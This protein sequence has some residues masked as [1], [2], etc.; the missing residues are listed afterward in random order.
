[1]S[2]RLALNIGASASIAAYMVH[3]VV[4][5]NLHIPA[6]VLL[7]AFV[8][9]IVAN[10]EIEQRETRVGER[11]SILGRFL[12]PVLGLTLAMQCYRLLPGEYFTERARSAQRDEQPEVAAAFALRGLTTEKWNP[13]LYR[14]LASAQFTLCDRISDPT[15]RTQCYEEPVTALEKARAVAPEDG[16][17]LVQL[18]SAY[19]AVGRY[20]EAEWVYYDARKWDPRSIYLDELYRFHL[21][22]WRTAPARLPMGQMD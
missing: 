1:L 18:A 8:F 13:N 22:Q 10:D 19:D 9:G 12:L 4:D 11:M 17:I 21:S 20:P 7:L 2:R 3:S 14:Y 15:A 16:V 6:N 5:F